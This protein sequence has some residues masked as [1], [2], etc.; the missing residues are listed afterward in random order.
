MPLRIYLIRHA[1]STWNAERRYAGS[2]DPPLSDT[3]QQQAEKVAGALQTV[4]V[5]AIYTSPLRRAAQTAFAIA[6]VH[7]AEPI[8][9]P[10]FSE[11]AIGEWEGLTLSE[12]EAGY[13]ELLRRWYDDPA[14]TRIPGGETVAEM[15]ARVLLAFRRITRAHNDEAIVIVG[16]GGV[17]RVI[18]LSVLDAP[19]SSY[20]RF[21]VPNA[22]ISMV[23]MDGHRGWLMALNDMAHLK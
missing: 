19:L 12:V 10:E 20:W 1:E 3:G 2:S 6:R 14:N 15:Q 9:V 21:R 4:S 18:L 8:V 23:E 7:A 11:H 17:N 16:H 5:H 13:A 22:G